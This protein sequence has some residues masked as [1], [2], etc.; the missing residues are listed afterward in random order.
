MFT[1]SNYKNS[2]LTFFILVEKRITC[3]IAWFLL[4][5]SYPHLSAHPVPLG[6][7]PP[8]FQSPSTYTSTS[9]TSLIFHSPYAMTVVRKQKFVTISPFLF[10]L[11]L[12][13]SL[14]F[15]IW[16]FLIL[17]FASPSFS[18]CCFL[19]SLAILMFCPFLGLNS[20]CVICAT[21]NSFI[22]VCFY[23]HL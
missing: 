12:C 1:Y 8:P 7:P 3:Y 19:N 17:L 6:I 20:Y 23:S 14:I 4:R 11:A 22:S 21:A 9:L 16:Q 10:P 15:I 2:Y 13:L 18:I 5:T